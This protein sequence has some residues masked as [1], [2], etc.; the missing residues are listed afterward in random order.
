MV[1]ARHGHGRRRRPP[2]TS[3]PLAHQPGRVYGDTLRTA[4]RRLVSTIARSGA[5][6][7]LLPPSARLFILCFWMAYSKRQRPD[8]DRQGNRVLLLLSEIPHLIN[9][10]E[11]IWRRRVQI[12]EPLALSNQGLEQMANVIGVLRSFVDI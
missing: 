5:R 3:V 1:P 8:L 2:R 11:N 12:L 4:I 10:A 7:S 6:A 9:L